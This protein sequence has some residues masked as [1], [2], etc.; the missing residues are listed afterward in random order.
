MDPILVCPFNERL[1][2]KLKQRAIVIHSDDF[3]IIRYIN[4]EVNTS[5]K[6]HAIKLQ[7]D[8]PVSE[9]PFLEEW[10]NI[11]LAIY[12]P[13]LGDYKE[14][15]HRLSLIRKLNLRIFLTS[16]ID[17]N[18]VALRILS[19]FN[20]SCGL[21]FNEEPFNWDAINDLMH[22]AVYN[23][24]KHAPIEPFHWLISHY[25]PVEYLDYNIVYFN[26]PIKYLHLNETGQISLT[27]EDL[28]INKYIAGGV[29]SL[30]DI[31]NNKQYIDGLNRRYKIMLSMNECAFCQAFRIC[32]AKFPALKNKKDTCKNFF[33]DFLNAADFYYSSIAK[34][35]NQLWQL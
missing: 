1:L 34:I 21:Y 32:L 12:A 27:D 28:K 9:I 33:S 13:Q 20:I 8:K 23:Q 7:T 26:S 35:D 11:P 6:L 19:S 29:E 15:L 2:S 25:L 31:K 4:K 10:M 24:T 18:F 22:Y 14:F 5:N 3:N 30:D 17:F 16:Q